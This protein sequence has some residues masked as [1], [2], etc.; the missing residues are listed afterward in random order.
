[1][2]YINAVHNWTTWND[3]DNGGTLF[4]DWI[5]TYPSNEDPHPYEQIT[6]NVTTDLEDLA[7]LAGDPETLINHLDVMLTH[8]RLSN[9]TRAIIKDAITPLMYGNVNLNRAKMALYLFM[10]SPDYVVLK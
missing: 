8:G 5:G 9:E 10:I 7:V 4:W 1:M 6:P 2:G 3:N